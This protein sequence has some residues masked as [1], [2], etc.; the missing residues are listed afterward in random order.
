MIHIAPDIGY[1]F[2][3]RGNRTLCGKRVSD[4]VAANEYVGIVG[5]LD[6]KVIVGNPKEPVCPECQRLAYGVKESI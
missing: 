5:R 4:I 6:P 2:D 1:L 3:P